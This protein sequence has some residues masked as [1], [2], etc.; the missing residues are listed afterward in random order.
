MAAKKL[1]LKGV[2]G[3]LFFLLLQ[4]CM[5][6]K[7]VVDQI[8]LTESLCV[9]GLIANI[10]GS[11][12]VSVY[13]GERS[14]SGAIAIRCTYYKDKSL[15]TTSRFYITGDGYTLRTDQVVMPICQDGSSI[16]YV[17]IQE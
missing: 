15:W 11:R 2:S 16:V 3:L 7:R 1:S 14:D 13:V 12:C 4:G 6:S 9:D 8:G 17:E 5:S 10:D